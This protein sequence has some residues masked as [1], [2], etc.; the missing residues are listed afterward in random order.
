MPHLMQGEVNDFCEALTKLTKEFGIAIVG[1]VLIEP[2]EEYEMSDFDFYAPDES[3]QKIEWSLHGVKA[4]EHKMHP[5]P[6]TEPQ[7]FC[8]PVNGVHA[9][10]CTGHKSAGG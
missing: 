7:N 3:H 4:V 8:N 9:P 2:L 6:P 10:F 5:T 1:S